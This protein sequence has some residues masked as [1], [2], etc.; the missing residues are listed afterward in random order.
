[1]SIT[2]KQSDVTLVLSALDAEG[3]RIADAIYLL[4]KTGTAETDEAVK[5]LKKRGENIS[6]LK[7]GFQ[8][9]TTVTLTRDRHKEG[10]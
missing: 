8:L 10:I 5:S 9:S 3:D 6:S 2:L 7:L 4:L 1:M